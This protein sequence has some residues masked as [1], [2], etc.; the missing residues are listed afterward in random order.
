MEDAPSFFDAET[1]LLIG[2]IVLLVIGF[3]VLRR[4]GK[5]PPKE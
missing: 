2:L 5:R 3:L 4:Q 1:K